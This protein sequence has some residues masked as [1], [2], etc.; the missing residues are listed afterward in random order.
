MNFHHI[1]TIFK[2]EFTDL[3]RDKKTIIGTLIVPLL[4]FP[5][6]MLIMGGG[7]GSMM[8]DVLEDPTKLI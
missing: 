7:L 2:K 6:L 3:F 1:G 5:L 8:N 4:L